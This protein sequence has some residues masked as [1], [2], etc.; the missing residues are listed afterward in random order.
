MSGVCRRRGKRGTEACLYP[1]MCTRLTHLT[2]NPPLDGPLERELRNPGE[3]RRRTGYRPSW[4]R[5]CCGLACHR[6]QQMH[7]PTGAPS[8]HPRWQPPSAH[9]C[10]ALPASE[11]C[12]PSRLLGRGTS[13]C[14]VTEPTRDTNRSSAE[15]GS[16]QATR[17][18]TC[19]GDSPA[20]HSGCDAH[21]LRGDGRDGGRWVPGWLTATSR[22]TSRP[23]SCR[24]AEPSLPPPGFS[25]VATPCPC[26]EGNP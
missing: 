9:V 20:F 11:S 22:S 23:S 10:R 3:T 13:C 6:T 5:A 24:P 16:Q 12:P 25:G 1:R 15:G 19:P 18:P 7:A 4:S 21:S 8:Q 17:L 26:G 14:H 2:A